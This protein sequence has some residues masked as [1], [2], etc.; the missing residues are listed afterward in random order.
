[1][2]ICQYKQ[3]ENNPNIHGYIAADVF[4]DEC[5]HR[6]E[7]MGEQSPILTSEEYLS[8]W[9]GTCVLCNK[10]MDMEQEERL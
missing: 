9:D 7:L 1:M 3:P 6:M 8:S 10:T 5:A 4:C 2:K